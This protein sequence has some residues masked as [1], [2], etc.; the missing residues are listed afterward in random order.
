LRAELVIMVLGVFS[1][2]VL[3]VV[4]YLGNFAL[5]GGVLGAVRLVG[6]S[7]W[8]VFVSGILPHGIF[9]LPSVIL[10]CAAVLHMGLRLVTPE[11]GHSIGETLILTFADVLKILLAVCLPLLLLAALIESNLTPRL[12]LAAIG[13]SFDIKP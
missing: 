5:I 9:E 10:I 6:V 7:P 8:L 11:P 13:H 3:S 2:G 4:A 1:F 12:L